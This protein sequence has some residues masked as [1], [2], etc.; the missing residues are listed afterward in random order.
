[1]GYT[2]NMEAASRII[3]FNQDSSAFTI[4]TPCGFEIYETSP[5][6]K[7]GQCDLSHSLKICEMLYTSNIFALVAAEA[8]GPE[9]S[10]STV[11]FWDNYS[12][13]RLG[14][15]SFPREVRGVKMCRSRAAIATDNSVFL[16]CLT[17]L[18][19]IRVLETSPNPEGLLAF[20]L[21][22]PE[23]L[24][25]PNPDIGSVSIIT[26]SHDLVL[27]AH[28]RQLSSLALNKSGSM[29]AT[30][31]TKGTLI[32]VFSTAGLNKLFEF[33]RGSAPTS[34]TDLVFHPVE[35][36]LACASLRGTVHIYILMEGHNKSSVVSFARSYLP[37]YFSSE[38]SKV[39][40]RVPEGPKKLAFTKDSFLTVLRAEGTAH[41]GNYMQAVSGEVL[42]VRVEDFLEQQLTGKLRTLLQ[43]AP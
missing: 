4:T 21:D 33:R 38:W 19:H 6:K 42:C 37:R 23:V 39:T 24:V 18:T 13:Q 36:L 14:Q 34:I 29:L 12:H 10:P 30:T 1:M 5:L 20:S 8:S 41:I 2:F 11:V 35:Q 3:T 17:N 43:Y 15:K 32:R 9:V 25:C 16:Y 7:L 28:K 31:S 22:S 40:F 27:K 26:S